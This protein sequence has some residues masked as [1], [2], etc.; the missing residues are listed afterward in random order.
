MASAGEDYINASSVLTFTPFSGNQTRN[1]TVQILS[2]SLVEYDETFEV[3]LG[4]PA[5][6]SS[7]AQLGDFDKAIFKILD[8]D[9]KLRLLK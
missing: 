9:S 2:D 5:G 7:L 6:F 8:D 1:F 3:H 4:I